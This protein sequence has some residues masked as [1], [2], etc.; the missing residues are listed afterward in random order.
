MNAWEIRR[1]S[2]RAALIVLTGGGTGLAYNLLADQGIY[3]QPTEGQL[4]VD[5][6]HA[7]QAFTQ[8]HTIFLDARHAWVYEE[9]HIS[10]AVNIPLGHFERDIQKRLAHLPRDTPIITYCSGAACHSSE[11]LA[12]LLVE[13]F[14]FV[15]VQ[16]L[17][18][19]WPAWEEAGYPAEVGTETP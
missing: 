2:F 4:M 19:G 11:T 5:L 17:A 14:G 18:G 16:V 8:G 3:A 15:Q 12:R 10:G 7:R 13:R 6:A 1:L 9:G